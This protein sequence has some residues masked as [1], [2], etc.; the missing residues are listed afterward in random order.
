MTRARARS[1]APPGADVYQGAALSVGRWKLL[2]GVGNDTWHPVPSAAAPRAVL[3][4]APGG[5][6]CVDGAPPAPVDA[7]FDIEADPE[8]RVD[9]YALRPDVVAN[10]SARLALWRARA[11]PAQ[12]QPADPEGAAAAARCGAWVPFVPAPG[13]C[14]PAWCDD[15]AAN[16]TAR[17]AVAGCDSDELKY[18]CSRTC[19][20]C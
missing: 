16:C 11:V 18:Y 5:G 1:G 20:A 9:L 4:C 17:A 14:P 10:L 8:E 3:R 6:A 2:V 12:N 13:A 15:I 19:G 7:L